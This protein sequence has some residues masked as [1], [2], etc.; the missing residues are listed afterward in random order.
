MSD[1]TIAR[2]YAS[3]LYGEAESA[4]TV[5]MIDND[6]ELLFNTLEESHDLQ[7]FF[8][9]PVISEEKK[10]TVIRRLFQP[11]VSDLM[12]NFLLFVISKQREG[13]VDAIVNEYRSMRL[14]QRGIVE[15]DARV[16]IP[17]DET[18]VD[19]LTASI[20]KTVGSEIRLNVKTDPELVGGVVVQIGDLVYDGTLKRKL[21]N[22]RKQMQ[23]GSF[24]NN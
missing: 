6:V 24:R 5:E 21:A 8:A 23:G 4:G 18:D 15:A 7:L 10:M 17:L 14:K 11:R 9:S 3:A 20:S 2:R 13:I 22:L 16:A 1:R 12:L 19:D